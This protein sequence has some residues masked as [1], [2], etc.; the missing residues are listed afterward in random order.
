MVRDGIEADVVIHPT[1]CIDE[2]CTI[3]E[4]TRIWHFV[5]VMAGARIG[6]RCMLG[7]GVFVAGRVVL[8]DGVRVQNHVSLYDGIT[9]DDDVFLGP[10]CVFTNVKTPRAFIKREPVETRVLR[11]ATIGANSTILC[12]TTIGRYALIGAG[13]VVTSD[14]PEFALMVGAPARRVGTV[15]EAGERVE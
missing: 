3:G 14:V 1:A 12:G 11:G 15:N 4:G 8:G 6:R 13:A 5:H 7:Q 9:I 2:P 10:S